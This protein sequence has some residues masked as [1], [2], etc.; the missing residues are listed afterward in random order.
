MHHGVFDTNI[1]CALDYLTSL[2]KIRVYPYDRV[3]K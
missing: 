2:Y 3:F 1:D